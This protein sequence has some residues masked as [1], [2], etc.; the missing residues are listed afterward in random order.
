MTKALVAV[1]LLACSHPA[2]PPAK[3]T[4]PPP[5][6]QAGAPTCANVRDHL[7]EILSAS[8][9]AP[10]E[11]V[12][13]LGAKFYKH[14]TSDAWSAEARTCLAEATRQTADT[15][16]PM[17]TQAQL[18]AISDDVDGKPPGGGAPP[19]VDEA[20]PQPAM[21]PPPPAP[22]PPPAATKRAPTKSRSSDPCEGG[23]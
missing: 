16:E 11:D 1:F 9:D 13:R 6:P 17:L 19:P 12:D 21:A 7:I 2:A 4:D 8:K 3:P 23:Q 18:T 14:C 5:P 10:K 22:P 15:C 20:K